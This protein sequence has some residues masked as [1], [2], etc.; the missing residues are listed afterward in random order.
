MRGDHRNESVLVLL[1]ARKDRTVNGTFARV[2][3]ARNSRTVAFGYVFTP[4]RGLTRLVHGRRRCERA[5]SR[6][7]SCH[8]RKPLPHR[9]QC[10]NRS[11]RREG[12]APALSG[13]E[14]RSWADHRVMVAR[15]PQHP[16]TAPVHS[17]RPAAP[18]LVTRAAAP[19]V[20][21]DASGFSESAPGR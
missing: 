18:G 13:E 17:S 19:A 7:G 10:G 1:F 16:G 2:A 11:E 12:M 15:T 3:S 9:L 21:R 4:S 8:R 5:G 6:G 20:H 14:C